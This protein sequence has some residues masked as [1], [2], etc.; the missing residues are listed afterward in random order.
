MILYRMKNHTVIIVAG[1]VLILTFVATICLAQDAPKDMDS[2][3]DLRC[4]PISLLSACL[5]LGYKTSLT[6]LIN[7]S[8]LDERGTT[9]YGLKRAAEKQGLHAVAV[10]VGDKNLHSILKW[11]VICQLGDSHFVSV[12]KM[13]NNYAYVFDT[14]EYKKIDLEKF[15]KRWSG[16]ALLIDKNEINISKKLLFISSPITGYTLITVGLILCLILVIRSR[17]RASN[18]FRL[19][20]LIV[21]VFLFGISSNVFASGP[22]ISFENEAID[23]GVINALKQKEIEIDFKFVNNGDEKLEIS[24]VKTSCGCMPAKLST[25]VLDPGEGGTVS[26]EYEIGTVRGSANHKV[27]VYSND[28]ERPVVILTVKSVISWPVNFAPKK[29]IFEDILYGDS[30]EKSIRIL[31]EAENI[32]IDSVLSKSGYVSAIPLEEKDRFFN[33]HEIIIAPNVNLKPGEYRDEVKIHLT[34]FGSEKQVFSVP[35]E[36]SIKHPVVAYPIDVFFGL[37]RPGD[38][39]LQEVDISFPG[40]GNREIA[41]VTSSSEN[42]TADIQDNGDSVKLVVTLN[43]R[44]EGIHEGVL[45]VQ[46]ADSALPDLEIPFWGLVSEK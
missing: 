13:D 14:D 4:G 34:Q 27:Y 40:E 18:S 38:E 15:K 37:V 5:Q 30:K 22:K 26:I 23:V 1:V 9:F 25:K 7:D 2:V 29:V 43:S 19:L 32:N 20:L 39:S 44:K 35:V 41:G 17:K 45:S 3:V 46:F 28:P 42:V 24:Q 8:G 36:F 21:V 33:E 31:A 6:D 11:K 16:N 10:N 12:L